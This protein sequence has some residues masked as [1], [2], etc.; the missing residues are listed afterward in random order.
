MLFHLV[1]NLPG[2]KAD[3][4]D[5]RAVRTSRCAHPAAVVRPFRGRWHLVRYH[6]VSSHPKIIDKLIC[7]KPTGDRKGNKT[8]LSVSCHATEFRDILWPPTVLRRSKKFLPLLSVYPLNG[9]LTD[10]PLGDT[11][12][13][14]VDGTH[15]GSVSSVHRRNVLVL[16]NPCPGF[17]AVVPPLDFL[18]KN[19]S[20]QE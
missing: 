12:Y 8:F 3:G 7:N 4:F 20:I 11:I 9:T 17:V 5:R 19:Q 2:N 16:Q 6:Q 10:F 18:W 13:L 1:S 15:E 14:T